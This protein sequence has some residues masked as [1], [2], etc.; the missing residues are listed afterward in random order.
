M[1]QFFS[2]NHK[3]IFVFLLFTG[4]KTYCYLRWTRHKQQFQVWGHL[5]KVWTGEPQRI[6]TPSVFPPWLMK[7]ASERKENQ[8]TVVCDFLSSLCRSPYV[9]STIPRDRL[10]HSLSFTKAI[11]ALLGTKAETLEPLDGFAADIL[12]LNAA[13]AVWRSHSLKAAVK[14]NY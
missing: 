3:Q 14:I 4:L 2:N 12:P 9:F 6:Q 5:S 1:T 10:Q 13:L 11:A 7:S 8:N